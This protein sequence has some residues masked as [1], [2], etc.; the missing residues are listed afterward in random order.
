MDGSIS[1]YQNTTEGAVIF[2]MVTQCL[3]QLQGWLLLVHLMECGPL[4]LLVLHAYVSIYHSVYIYT[5]AHFQLLSLKALGFIPSS[6]APPREW[7]LDVRIEEC[8]RTSCWQVFLVIKVQKS[9]FERS[10]WG[11]NAI[12]IYILGRAHS[13]LHRK[14]FQPPLSL[15]HCCMTLTS[16]PGSRHCLHF[17]TIQLLI[18]WGMHTASD[19]L[20]EARKAWKWAIV[21]PR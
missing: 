20:L 9:C 19:Q 5:W 8:S 12:I 2:F 17:P 3:F 4:T 1:P 15:F 7:G 21:L 13:H 11:W 10:F 18:T 14:C 6:R 16:F